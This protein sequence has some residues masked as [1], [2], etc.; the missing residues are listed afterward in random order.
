MLALPHGG[1]N[2][3]SEE[4]VYDQQ[5][6]MVNALLFVCELIADSPYREDVFRIRRV[7]L[8]LRAKSVDMR[9]HRVIVP[10]EL[11]A[12]DRVEEILPCVRFAGSSGKCGE[13]VEFLC[14]QLDFLVVAY[15]R[16][17]FEIDSQI[18][19]L[20]PISAGALDIFLYR[21]DTPEDRFCPGLKLSETEGLRQV[22][23]R[24]KLK[25]EHLVKFFRT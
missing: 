5:V 3:G 6:T 22:V 7:R 9:V 11:I 19:K 13:Q 24:A 18:A 17:F 20:Y 12:P 4:A 23:I 8:D 10:L 2:K 15:Y 25:T 14:G 21:F 16:P 1:W